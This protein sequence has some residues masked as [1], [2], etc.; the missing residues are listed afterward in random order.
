MDLLRNDASTM[1]EKNGLCLTLFIKNYF[2]VEEKIN[3]RFYFWNDG[4]K[5]SGDMLPRE[6]TITG[7]MIFKTIF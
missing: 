5:S 7:K 6:T 1:W 4:I 2:H 3:M